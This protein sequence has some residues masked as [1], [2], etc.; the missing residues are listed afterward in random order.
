GMVINIATPSGTNRLKGSV[1]G[2]FTARS[3]NGNNTPGGTPVV[4]QTV[5]PDLAVGGPIQKDKTWFF[6]TFRYTDRSTGVSRNA[7][8]LA[9]LETRAVQPASKTTVSMDLTYFKPA[10][11]LGSHE[12]QTG[13]YLQPRLRNTSTT[14]YSNT[15]FAL[16]EVALRDPGNASA[17]TV[18]FHRRY[19]DVPSIKTVDLHASDNAL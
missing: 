15:G 14:Y 17:G 6:G 2:V 19:Y 11:W 10:G 3:W 8:L 1:G 16:E 4:S 7:E 5:Q 13:V 12:I 9:N 18:P